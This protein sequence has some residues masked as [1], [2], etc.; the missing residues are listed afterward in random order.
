MSLKKKNTKKKKFTSK[1]V[2]TSTVPQNKLNLV[3]YQENLTAAT[4]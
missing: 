3:T 1:Q 4:L 2:K